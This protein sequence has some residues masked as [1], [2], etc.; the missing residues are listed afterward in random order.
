MNPYN[1]HIIY[2]QENYEAYFAVEDS[3]IRKGLC[4]IGL[5]SYNDLAKKNIA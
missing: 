5:I 3:A 4:S 1:T 2:L